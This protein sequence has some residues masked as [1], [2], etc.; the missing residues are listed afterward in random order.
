MRKTTKDSLKT[1]SLQAKL[2]LE[3]PNMKQKHWPSDLIV[4]ASSVW[5]VAEIVEPSLFED[6]LNMA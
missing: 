3:P 1:M 6:Y 4:K 5:N 2:N